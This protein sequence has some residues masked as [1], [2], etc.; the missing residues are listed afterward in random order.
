MGCTPFRALNSSVSC[1]SLAVPEYQPATDRL[2]LIKGITLTLKGSAGAAGTNRT[3][4]T[5]NPSTRADI[6]F[7]FNAVG[8]VRGRNLLRAGTWTAFGR[9]LADFAYRY[10]PLGRGVDGLVGQFSLLEQASRAAVEEVDVFYEVPPEAIPIGRGF[11]WLCVDRLARHVEEHEEQW[12]AVCERCVERW[13]EFR[14]G[15]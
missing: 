5:D 13:E 8:P 11:Y 14:A 2:P 12:R 7:A 6:A 10:T 15:P 9:G 1:E 4:F 3:P